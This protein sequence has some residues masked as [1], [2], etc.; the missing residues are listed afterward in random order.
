MSHEGALF[1][2][3]IEAMP[4]PI[5]ASLQR[6]LDSGMARRLGDS[7]SMP[8]N[9]RLIASSHRSLDVLVEAGVV[10]E[11]LAS[12]L[13]HRLTLPSLTERGDDMADL[14][15]HLTAQTAARLGR[16]AP[17]IGDEVVAALRARS[18]P[19][20]VAQLREVVEQALLASGGQA[21]RVEHLQP[22]S[23]SWEGSAPAAGERAS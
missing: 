17:T 5:Q 7:T 8:V 11:A 16:P 10:Q 14:V 20:N 21:L 2:K 4:L 12:S 1:L 18:F 9:V 13:R 15:H 19:G 6:A 23:S 22:A 3:D